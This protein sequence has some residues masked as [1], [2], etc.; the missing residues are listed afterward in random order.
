MN[1]R[2][3]FEKMKMKKKKKINAFEY[4][5]HLLISKHTKKQLDKNP[6]TCTHQF[7]RK[8]HSYKSQLL[9]K[10]LL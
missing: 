5:P 8:I 2:G 6:S 4:R 1:V 7:S 9:I 10:E 3:D